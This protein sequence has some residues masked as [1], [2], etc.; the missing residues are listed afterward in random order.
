MGVLACFD[1]WWPD[2]NVTLAGFATI[3]MLASVRFF[4]LGTLK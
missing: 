2:L 3:S 4:L 1:P